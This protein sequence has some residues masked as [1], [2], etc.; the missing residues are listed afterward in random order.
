MQGVPPN[1]FNEPL[2]CGAT[3]AAAIETEQQTSR[4]SAGLNQQ[5]SLFRKTE[6]GTEQA[7]RRQNP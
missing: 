7:W 3:D 2:A 5:G 4:S 6:R 1:P